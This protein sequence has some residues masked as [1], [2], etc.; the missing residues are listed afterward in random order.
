MDFER[1]SEQFVAEWLRGEGFKES[2][3]EAFRGIYIYIYIIISHLN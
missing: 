1:K 3:V 2:V